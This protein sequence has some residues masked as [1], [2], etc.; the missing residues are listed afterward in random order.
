MP[1][2]TLRRMRAYAR[3]ERFAPLHAV[4]DALVTWL[5]V[6]YDVDVEDDLSVGVDVLRGPKEFN[7]SV[8]VTPRNE[9][10]AAQRMS[11]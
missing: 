9:S 6:A 2:P 4:A 3:L 7:R 5:R 8:R 1:P 11:S 10:A